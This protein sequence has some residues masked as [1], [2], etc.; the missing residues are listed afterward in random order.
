M[1]DLPAG[2]SVDAVHS[3]ITY[4]LCEFTDPSVFN[5]RELSVNNTETQVIS[6][7]VP[8]GSTNV[9]GAVTIR[10]NLRK[11]L[12]AE[13]IR[14]KD[15][16]YNMCPNPENAPTVLQLNN[17]GGVIIPRNPNFRGKNDIDNETLLRLYNSYKLSTMQGGDQ[18]DT[19]ITYDNWKNKY[20]IYGQT[21]GYNKN[22]GSSWKYEITYDEPTKAAVEV[23]FMFVGEQNVPGLA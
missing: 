1:F 7:Y 2:A 16:I 3:Q 5:P 4:P 17:G 22:N 14:S 15:D 20:R 6:R 12:V 21:V 9:S 13:F 18:V 10:Y 19:H 8:A 11:V 23:V